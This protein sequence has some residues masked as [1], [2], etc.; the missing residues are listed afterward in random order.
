M[1]HQFHRDG[2]DSSSFLPVVA[3]SSLSAANI[4]VR[5]REDAVADQGQVGLSVRRGVLRM[6]GVRLRRMAQD[7]TGVADVSLRCF[8]RPI[9][10]ANV[11]T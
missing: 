6:L 10:K 1:P 2:I 7:V 8:T 4:T 5:G 11:A 3:R 9:V